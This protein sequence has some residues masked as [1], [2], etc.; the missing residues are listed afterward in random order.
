MK[1]LTDTLRIARDTSKT[2]NTLKN[3]PSRNAYSKQNQYYSI[4]MPRKGNNINNF[5]E[6]RPGS[7][8]TKILGEN[9]DNL[10]ENIM[11]RNR[12]QSN[13]RRV[14]QNNALSKIINDYNT[15][16][17]NMM[18]GSFIN[19]N[20]NLD[21]SFNSNNIAPLYRCPM[22]NNVNNSVLNNS[23]VSFI[24]QNNQSHSASK[25]PNEIYS[26]PFVLINGENT[27]NL[28]IFHFITHLR[29]KE[30]DNLKINIINIK[31]NFFI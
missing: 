25:T 27:N 4:N 14:K 6:F 9:N 3:Y 18:N 31:I 10:I 11:H 17:I 29:E 19:N 26:L 16:K 23:N 24:N 13:I 5:R 28:I 8:L 20:V 21:S 7:F 30:M 15:Q 22:N 2:P 1:I 12:S